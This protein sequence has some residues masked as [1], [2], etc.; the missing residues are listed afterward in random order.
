MGNRPKRKIVLFLVEGKSEREALHIDESIEVF[1]PIIRED[2]EE[3]G[4][5]ITSRNWVSPN[6]IEDKMY[7][8]FLKNFFDEEKIFPKDIN[9]IIQI[10]DMDGAYIPDNDIVLFD[11]PNSEE[12][13]FYS[14]SSII[15]SNVD[16]MITR[17]LRK[18][19]NFDYLCSLN[20]IK[21]KQKTVPYSVYFF[22]SNIDHFLHNDANL[23]CKKKCSLAEQF[24][25]GFIGKTEDFIKYIS[26]SSVGDTYEASW[27]YIKQGHNSLQRHTNL[28]LLFDLLLNRKNK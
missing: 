8:L 26:D 10:V 12:K 11:D 15:C 23:S 28:K 2:T 17:N 6:N 9:E 27:Q 20:A 21:V 4:G 14:Q 19:E 1:F 18:R 16:Y 24:A 5:D 7:K 13:P 3:R 25:K 22:S